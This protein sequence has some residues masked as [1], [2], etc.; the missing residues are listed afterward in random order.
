MSSRTI[1]A[2]SRSRKPA[3]FTLVELLV[4]IGIIAV[5][6]GILLPV[7]NSARRQASDVACSANLRTLVQGL[8]IY[9][10]ENKGS[11]PYGFYY[12]RQNYNN[13]NP[14]GVEQGYWWSSVINARLTKGSNNDGL[15]TAR[16]PL[17]NSWMTYNKAFK[18]PSVDSTN[19]NGMTDYQGHTVAMPHLPFEINPG[20]SFN[21][22]WP[23][24]GGAPGQTG[25]GTPGIGRQIK[26]AK[27]T[28]LYPDNAL[29]WDTITW[30]NNQPDNWPMPF[31]GVSMI[32]Y[33]NLSVPN[34]PAYSDPTNSTIPYSRRYRSGGADPYA[35]LPELAEN[36]SIM[37]PSK[38]RMPL[39]WQDMGRGTTFTFIQ[40]G[41]ARFR[42]GK[43]NVVN[44][45]FADGS[46]RGLSVSPFKTE[47]T[48]L[49]M[50]WVTSDFKRKMLLLKPSAA[51]RR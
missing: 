42:H 39:V 41:M 50:D 35:A 29:L 25:E 10:N 2:P 12:N 18:C 7:V 34:D 45:A 21:T 46:V 32:D 28:Q 8:L 33:A 15:W 19:G 6:I 38:A 26:P 40:P 3:A 13:G 47:Y 23:F 27:L 9:A 22:Y 20:S 49:G 31:W 11:L 24:V 37:I 14:I 36:S 43:Q 51:R 16:T 44:V 5:L 48:A 17:R 1:S 30:F 4:V